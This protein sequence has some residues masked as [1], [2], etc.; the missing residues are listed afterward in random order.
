MRKSPPDRTATL[1][2][3]TRAGIGELVRAAGIA[4]P[5]VCV[6]YSGGLDSVVLLDL[7]AL[8]AAAGSITVTAVH[9]HHGLSPN[10]DAWSGHCAQVCTRLGIELQIAR[11]RIRHQAGHSPEEEARTARYAVFRRIQADAVALAHHA[12]DQAETVLLQL[13]RGA[14]PKGLAAMAAIVS[15]T[16]RGSAPAYWRPLL[17]IDRAQLAA[18]AV[19][20]GLEW[21]EDESNQDLRLRRNYLRQRVLPVI[22]EAF[23]APGRLLA[24]AARL[25][26]QAASLLEVL[27]D[28]DLAM[29]ALDGGLDCQRLA[30]LQ[31]DRQANLLRRWL[32]QAGARAPSSARLAALQKAIVDS[33]NDTRLA[34]VH[35][36]VRVVRRK[37]VL[38]LENASPPSRD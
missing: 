35:E 14:G 10:A 24:R 15:R 11:V 21:V 22:A 7:L 38:L 3:A 31:G 37:A 33:S 16:V 8:E 23:P 19:D 28:L 2:A 5:R 6:G 29:M 36:G 30:M 26:A 9:V 1:R 12:D 13:L 18:Y 27:A 32:A 20:A 4:K 25:Q 34:W 17:S